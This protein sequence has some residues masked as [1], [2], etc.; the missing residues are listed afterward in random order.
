MDFEQDE[1]EREDDEDI[2]TDDDE[3]GYGELF[4]EY[5]DG[6]GYSEEEGIG[7]D[8]SE[9]DEG[10]DIFVLQEGSCEEEG[11]GEDDEDGDIVDTDEGE[12]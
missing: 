4:S 7:K 11:E 9:S 3:V 8:G 10:R 5:G 6:E 12:G 1:D 2:D